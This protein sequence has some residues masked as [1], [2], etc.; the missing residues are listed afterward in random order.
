MRKGR[1]KSKNEKKLKVRGVFAF[2]KLQNDYVKDRMYTHDNTFTFED[3]I[4]I[5]SA[6]VGVFYDH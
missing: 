6:W 3:F 4:S 5:V 1:R 2:Y